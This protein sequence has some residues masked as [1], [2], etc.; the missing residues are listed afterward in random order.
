LAEASASKA[1]KKASKSAARAAAATDPVAI[2]SKAAK[3][4]SKSAARAAA[5]TDPAAIAAKA[6]RLASKSA[7]KV[8]HFYN[9]TPNHSGLIYYRLPLLLTLLQLPP[10]QADLLL[11]HPNRLQ[12]PLLRCVIIELLS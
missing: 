7:A 8:N 5:A 4:A 1:A 6:E 9:Y 11:R 2:A 10:R 12:G 3:K